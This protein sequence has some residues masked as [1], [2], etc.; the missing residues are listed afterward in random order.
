MSGSRYIAAAVVVLLGLWGVGALSATTNAVGKPL[1]ADAAPPAQ[2]VITGL[3]QPATTLDFFVSVYKR[4]QNVD[5]NSWSDVLSTPLVRLDKDFNLVPAA[6]KSWEASKD[7]LTWTFH[8]DRGLTWS[9]GTPLTADDFV[10]TFRLGADPKQAW[11]FAWFFS[12]IKGWD[13][14]VKGTIPV[15]QIGVRRGADP[16]TLVVTTTVPAPY[17][18]GMMLY[19]PPLQAKAL[20]G[21]GPFYN[22][23]PATSVSSGPYL[24]REWTKDQRM[25]LVANPKYSGVKP[26]IQQVVLKFA[27]LKTEFQ[28]YQANEVDVAANFSPADLQVIENDPALRAQ[29][30]QGFGDFRTYYV[31]FD[32]LHQPFDNLKVR[33]AFSHAIDRAGLIKNVIKQQGIAAYGFLMPGFP[34]SQNASLQSVQMYNPALAKTLL[35]EA[36][37]PDGKGFPKL[38]LWLRSERA[39][40]QAVG[41]AIGAMLKQNL[42][43]E[44]EVSNRETKLFM[45]ELNGHRLQ[46][47]MVSYGMDFLDPANMLGIW[48]SGGR[49]AW[50]NPRFDTLVKTAS[51]MVGD[52]VRRMAMF[53]DAE[54]L[55][56][57]DVGFIPIYFVTPGFM[58]KPYLKGDALRADKIGVTAW[59]WPG[60][61]GLS[62]LHQSVYV[63]QDVSKYR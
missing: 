14:A 17:L 13:D 58:W 34:G 12:V 49:H 2:Q 3:T 43:I 38:E 26:F 30:H 20:A 52:P 15:G 37:Y 1:P 42:G 18:P 4:P 47:Y 11:D 27:D 8:L 31:G 51:S 44:V 53:H 16:Y 22:T 10:A 29:Y 28:A 50:V 62:T 35:A 40:G 63:S 5:G 55:L 6:A 25:V 23:D 39:L 41:N 24:L 9:D 60:W 59:H 61:D 54:T 57:T 32:T 19:S 56:V 33:Q 7:G 36:G 21:V 48:L 45:D 46:L